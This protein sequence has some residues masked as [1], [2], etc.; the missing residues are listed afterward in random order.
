MRPHLTN[1]RLV[2]LMM[3]LLTMLAG[4]AS[5]FAQDGR[6]SRFTAI[7]LTPTSQYSATIVKDGANRPQTA[8]APTQPAITLDQDCTPT[9]FPKGST[10]TCTITAQNITFSNATVSITDKLPNQLKLV[11]NSV[12]GGTASGNTV[13]FNGSLAGA[14]APDVSVAAVNP[15]STPGEGYLPLS[16]FGISPVSGVGD[17]TITNFNVPLFIYAGELYSRLGVG[18]NGIVVVGGST[19]GAD[20]TPANQSLPN[21]TPPNNVLAGFWTDLNPGAGGAVRVA[22]LGDGTNSWI[23]VDWAS[24]REYS[25]Q[26]NLH[27]FEMWIGINGVEDITINYGTNTGNGDLNQATIGAENRFG[28]RGGN[29]F[30]NGTGTLPTTSDSLAVRVTGTAPVPGAAQVLTFTATGAKTG[31]WTN[32]AQMTSN[33]YQGINV[34]PFSGTV[35]P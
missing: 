18:S 32:Y 4:S 11:K 14:Q 3:V 13:S 25:G 15:L 33:L 5:A 22:I 16:L 35:T 12:T 23:V 31:A 8:L 28:N 21:A 17:N 20:A 6:S 29:I 19:S 1:R 9:S 30:Y 10:T 34:A 2:S 7:P 24:V 26:D 27:S